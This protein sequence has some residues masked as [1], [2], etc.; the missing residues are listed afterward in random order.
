MFRKMSLLFL[1]FSLLGC[2]KESINNDNPYL[3]NYRFS[4]D[5]NIALPTYSQVQFAGNSVKVNVNGAGNRGLILF[6]NGS[7]ILAYDGACP[8]QELS[9]CSTLS[10]SDNTATCPCDNAEYNLFNGQ[11]PGKTYP[12]KPYRTQVN[13]NVVNISN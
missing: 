9:S 1:F 10:I 13:G 2:N 5:I 12:L 11:S 6:N 4:V 7:T 3:A 8:N